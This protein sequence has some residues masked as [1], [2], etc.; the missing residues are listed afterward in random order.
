MSA[1]ALYPI[2][3]KYSKVISE[4]KVGGHL[5]IWKWGRGGKKALTLGKK[6]H[7]AQTQQI[8]K[9]V[10]LFVLSV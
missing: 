1:Y 8:F 7:T 3:K 2:L 6:R 5:E 4:F 9:L 10:F